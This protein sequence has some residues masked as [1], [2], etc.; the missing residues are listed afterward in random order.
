MK[1]LII[2]PTTALPANNGARRRIYHTLKELSKFCDVSFVALL[3]DPGEKVF[4]PDI[5]NY[6]RS[7][8][9][10][11]W[12]KRTKIN[13]AFQ[14]L[15]NL[16]P[17]RVNRF[18]NN[19]MTL[20]ITDLVAENEFDVIW[21]N[22]LE[23]L[24]FVPENTTN[25]IIM[26]D[27]HNDDFAMWKRISKNAGSYLHRFFARLNSLYLLRFNRKNKSRIDV[28]MAV[29]QEDLI[30][31][32]SWKYA[33]TDLWLVPN[34]VDLSYFSGDRD[35]ADHPVILFCGALDMEMNVEAVQ[36][37]VQKI[38]PGIY[39]ALPK[40]EFWIVGRDPDHRILDLEKHT[41]IQIHASVPDVRPYY[42]AAWA[43]VSPYNLGGGSKLKVLE[44]MAMGVPLVATTIGCQGIDVE[45]GKN[46][47]VSDN[48]QVFSD[49][50][51]QLLE[52]EELRISIAAE[53]RKLAENKYGWKSIIGGLEER[54]WE[55]VNEKTGK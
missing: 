22:F 8:H 4:I 49:K 28:G 18:M 46:I 36:F 45:D 14:S 7:V 34:G 37:F 42:Q 25:E 47:M 12:N 50:L 52:N 35:P 21:V 17:Y 20:C 1:V 53:A 6:C 39:K 16:K 38:F 54:M 55:L 5:E 30:T 41:G 51:I 26:V 9:Y 11:P 23:L 2:S 43:A 3:Q 19:E 40:C 44:A 31:S 33:D 32:Q 29:S 15:F 13:V 24:S 10:F 48:N 27:Y